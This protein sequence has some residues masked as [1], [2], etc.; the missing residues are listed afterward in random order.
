[1]FAGAYKG[2]ERS[3]PI[4]S[5]GISKHKFRRCALPETSILGSFF[6]WDQ[7]TGPAVFT[8]CIAIS[9]SMLKHTI[10]SISSSFCS[11]FN[12]SLST[13][14]VP[15]DWKISNITP[16]FKSG[17]KCF[18]SNYR[19][20]S[21]LSLPSKLLERIVFNRLL[22][23]LLTNSILSPRQFGFRPGSSTQ[24]ALLVATHDWQRF[25]DRGYS[26]AAL[27]LDLSKALIRCPTVSSSP[28]CLTLVSLVL[29]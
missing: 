3:T 17:N 4:A 9:S 28:P 15:K 8:S 26:S 7:M 29:C 10:F 24:E 20:I 2:K 22:D 25:L 16:V 13:G 5:V 27:F 12:L 21:L 6:A 14:T 23:H 19:P 1:M 18:V 11:L